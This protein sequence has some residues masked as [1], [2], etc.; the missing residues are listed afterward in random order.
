MDI[1]AGH[2]APEPPPSPAHAEI[3]LGAVRHNVGVLVE[4]AAGA[5]VMA[6]VKADGYG[7]GMI[8]SAQAALQAGA[9]WLGVVHVAE[10]LALREAGIDAPVLVMMAIPGE[11]HAEAVRRGV[12]V[13]AGSTAMVTAIADA[14]QAAG[15]PARL[16]LKADTGLARGGA[17]MT[18]WP[19]V[20][21]AAL[22][23]Q[24]AGHLEITGLWSHFACADEPGHPSIGRQ[25]DTFAEAV[26][27]AEK[28]GARP[29][30][31]HIANTAAALTLPS[32]RYDLVRPGGAV[33]GLSTLP[34][35][36]PEPLR[37]AMTLRT[38]IAQAKRVPAGTGVSYGHRYV[39][40][41][42]STLGLV[43]LGYADGIPRHAS[44][45]A[46]IY[47]KRRRWGIAGT[48]CMDQFV[49]D[50][51]D[52]DVEAGTEIV[53]FG[54]G[55]GGEPTAQEWAD[56]LGTISY[57]IVTRIGNRVQRLYCGVTE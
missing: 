32:S 24:A 6:V 29:E 4:Q 14:A 18:E 28:A 1:P 15:R 2:R 23:A 52:E 45:S 56:S 25:L 27:Q 51:G 22:A 40:S 3:D 34:G 16:Q 47:A 49:V 38:R 5:Q 44:G 26:E 9:N 17:P 43:P 41:R 54:P 35:G 20:V 21:G 10:A 42:E 13:T 19:A 46:D 11:R 36:A 8:P 31:R 50:F 33:Y 48:V 7:H 12:D 37:P 53:L 30:V 39:T 57:E 55:T